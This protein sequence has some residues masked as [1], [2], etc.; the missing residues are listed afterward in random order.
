MALIPGSED[1][2]RRLAEPAG[3]MGAATP[4]AFG[5][6]VAEAIG[7][8]GAMQIRDEA[9]Q[10][11]QM[12]ADARE[13]EQLW[14]AS[15]RA[16]ALD[17]LQG[18]QA[19]L[20]AM[21]D[22]W[23]D[24]IRTGK[25][26]KDKAGEEWG[27]AVKDRIT[28]A[29]EDVP[30][31]WRQNVQRGLDADAARLT[32]GISKAIANRNRDDV[33][34]S[35]DAI[36]E[37]ESR[38]YG[39][40]PQ[41]SAARVDAALQS[42]GPSSNYDPA[43]LGKKAQAWREGAQYTTAFAAVTGSRQDAQALAKLDQQLRNPEYL[44]ALDPQKR[45]ELVDRVAGYRLHLDQQAELR[46]Q[47][48][49][50]ESERHLKK[51]EAAFNA[52]Q[53]VADKGTIVSPA[54]VEA[55]IQA[56]AGTPYQAAVRTTM[57][58]LRETGGAARQPIAQQTAQLDALDT[59]IARNGLTP[60]LAKRREQLQKVRD[61]SIE[62][63]KADPLR[64]GAE[65]GVLPEGLRPL[66]LS[67]GIQGLL[68]QLAERTQQAATVQAWA[69]PNMPVSPFTPQE[70]EQIGSLLRAMPLDGQE[71]AMSALTSALPARQAAALAKQI[72]PNDRPLALALAAG[73]SMTTEGRTV[74]KLIL[75]G[76]QAVKDKAIKEDENP[77]FGV[78]A[79]LA[80]EV[81]DALS[82]PNRESVIDSARLIY[83]GKQAAGE[84]VSYA[85]AVALAAGGPIVEH[86]GKRIPV[87][88]GVEV[89][90]RL[91]AYPAAAVASQTNDGQ[92]YVGGKPVPVAD[93]VSA[94]PG[95]QLEPVSLGR[96]MVRAGG[97]L[98]SNADRRPI[99]IE[100]R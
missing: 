62:A 74:A 31:E 10:R 68:P 43:Q 70:A 82:G 44:P 51:A 88:A 67:A 96:Y 36:L 59:L 13:Q 16:K 3:V 95:A 22:D 100:L 48:A 56:T 60:E 99:V 66:N 75:R 63:A 5:A 86:A 33:T 49:E 53:S 84:R 80:K 15:Q 93:F 2:G 25:A 41:G 34:T 57:E 78:R 11:Q 27:A 21:H 40:D 46:A 19:D 72:N 7:D 87:P 61:G 20:A 38:N 8:V 18:T 79:S 1:L 91:R 32:R 4:R 35:L 64:A 52:W 30:I 90:D 77:E 83:I 85:G 17:V 97:H 26:A 81:G 54:F 92:V 98:V 14:K 89:E 94:L 71:V 45:A 28:R 23:A 9:V 37:S 50:R 29:I 73:A 24:N 76:Q 47:R 58:T 6:P 12:L 55:T 42:L 69:G 39:R 65:R